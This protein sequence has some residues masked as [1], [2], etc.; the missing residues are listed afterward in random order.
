MFFETPYPSIP[1]AAAEVVSLSKMARRLD[2]SQK[3]LR[4]MA[5]A[6]R[7]PAIAAGPGRF[8]FS[9]AATE[10][11]LAQLLAAQVPHANVGGLPN[12]PTM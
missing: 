7:V 10:A 2:V 12:F 1:T 4:E 8:L 11:A 6:G 9:V 5:E 3:W